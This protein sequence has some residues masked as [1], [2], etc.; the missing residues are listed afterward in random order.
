[1]VLKVEVLLWNM[2]AL[3]WGE[4]GA[5]YCIVIAT[6]AAVMLS[7]LLCEH[8]PVAPPVLRTQLPEVS[9]RNHSLHCM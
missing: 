1:M 7:L 9:N 2:E 8:F 3:Y 4:E 6:C 5:C